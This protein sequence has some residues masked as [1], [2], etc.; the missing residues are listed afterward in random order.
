MDIDLD[1]SKEMD[2]KGMLEGRILVGEDIEKYMP[3]EG[4]QKF[5]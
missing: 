4:Y 5:V 2:R 1:Y 3:A